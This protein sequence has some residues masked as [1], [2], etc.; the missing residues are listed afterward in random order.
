MFKKWRKEKHY[1]PPWRKL[2]TN[3]ENTLVYSEANRGDKT[4]LLN[5][6]P[7]L[8]IVAIKEK[9]GLL[10]R[11]ERLRM[12]IGFSAEIIAAEKLFRGLTKLKP[13]R[14]AE[15]RAEILKSTS[16]TPYRRGQ[17]CYHNNEL[18]KTL[19]HTSKRPRGTSR[20]ARGMHICDGHA[21]HAK[22]DC[23]GTPTSC[24]LLE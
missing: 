10:K 13:I 9:G 1:N 6:E 18:A 23:R 7:S 8:S 5:V 4:Y 16:N 12:V 17:H 22:E 21:W 3:V 15:R 20:L 24:N 19:Q 11:K 14:T 2:E